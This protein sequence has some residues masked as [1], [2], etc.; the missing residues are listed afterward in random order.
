MN[1][2][3]NDDLYCKEHKRY[4]KNIHAIDQHLNDMSHEDDEMMI[5]TVRA[6]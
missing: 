2:Y 4:F 6:Q 3:G 5:Y 1:Y